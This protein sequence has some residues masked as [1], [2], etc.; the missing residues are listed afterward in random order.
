M[1]PQSESQT[2]E[3][4]RLGC[5]QVS[6]VIAAVN[7]N[8]VQLPPIDDVYLVED[9]IDILGSSDINRD[10]LS[11]M[12]GAGD[13]IRRYDSYYLTLRIDG[14]EIPVCEISNGNHDYALFP[15]QYIANDFS[16]NFNHADFEIYYD[17]F[18]L[19]AN[20]DVG[21]DGTVPKRTR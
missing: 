6:A 15:R 20:A 18:D 19:R 10:F 16:P 17:P 14:D 9:R 3:F 1:T 8:L 7:G 5:E 4:E 2:Q 12:L 11:R 21:D 13:V